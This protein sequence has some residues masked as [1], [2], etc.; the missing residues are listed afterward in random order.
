MPLCSSR[1]H[2]LTS[3]TYRFPARGLRSEKNVCRFPRNDG[4]GQELRK[5][6]RFS[7][8]AIFDAPS[9]HRREERERERDKGKKKERETEGKGGGG[10]QNDS[11]LFTGMTMK[12]LSQRN[13]ARAQPRC[14]ATRCIFASINN[15]DALR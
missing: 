13:V 6:V 9:S 11:I 8:D 7:F 15:T 4:A 14:S 3:C 1:S 12:K 5:N 2:A 10:R